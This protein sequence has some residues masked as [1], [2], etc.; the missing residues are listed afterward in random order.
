MQHRSHRKIGIEKHPALQGLGYWP[1]AMWW[2]DLR[3]YLFHWAI[4]L[5]GIVFLLFVCNFI[6]SSKILML[7]QLAKAAESLLVEQPIAFL[8]W[9]NNHQ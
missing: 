9:K 7:K 5:M 8:P 6:G 2:R 1:R 4:K 3:R